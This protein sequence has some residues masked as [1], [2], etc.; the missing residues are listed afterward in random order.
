MEKELQAARELSSRNSSSHAG[1]GGPRKHNDVQRT[2]RRGRLS[3][4][5]N[6]IPGMVNDNFDS[7]NLDPD[8]MKLELQARKQREATLEAA[9]AEKEIMEEEYRKKVEEAKK[10]EAALENDLANMWVLVAQLKKEGN[11]N[12]TSEPKVDDGDKDAIL[13]DR[14]APD[15]SIP[16][17]NIPKEEPLVVRLKVIITISPFYMTISYLCCSLRFHVVAGKLRLSDFTK[18]SPWATRSFFLLHFDYLNIT[19]L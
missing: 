4:R 12:Q 3:G 11:T 17:S 13:R 15:N 8:D 7:W 9:L 18:L 10:R 6:E 2:V 1:S 19:V 5:S 14:E 16:A